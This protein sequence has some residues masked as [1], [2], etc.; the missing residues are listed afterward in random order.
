MSKIKFTITTKDEMSSISEKIS[1]ICQNSVIFLKGD[2]GAG[3]TFF[4]KCLISK[5]C[6]ISQDAI[7]SPTFSICN[8]YFSKNGDKILHYDLYRIKNIDE[9]YEIGLFDE[10]GNTML[11]EWPQII[12]NHI[13]K[14]AKS[15]IE[16]DITCNEF[17]ERIVTVEKL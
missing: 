6:E 9:I 8:E 16:I 7:D 17:N 1:E 12:E 4:A 3:K 10:I 14:I 11:I 2:L 15:Y 13:K 5:L